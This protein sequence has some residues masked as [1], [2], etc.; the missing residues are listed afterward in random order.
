MG[1]P[2]G[3][4]CSAGGTH[5]VLTTGVSV[6]GQNKPP[7]PSRAEP[8]FVRDGSVRLSHQ[9]PSKLHQPPSKIKSMSVSYGTRVP[10]QTRTCVDVMSYQWN[11]GCTHCG[12]PSG[13]SPE[14]LWRRGVFR[15][16][17]L[18]ADE[19]CNNPISVVSGGCSAQGPRSRFMSASK[20]STHMGC[21]SCTAG[22]GV[23]GARPT[24]E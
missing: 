16:P 10:R 22:V 7:S 23:V 4:R 17:F 5:A 21:S 15:R 18:P 11:V 8:I 13:P 3:C 12:A 9:P 20:A 6:R 14:S 2:W 1:L 19:G 24:C